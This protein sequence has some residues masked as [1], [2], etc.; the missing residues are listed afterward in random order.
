MASTV[1]QLFAA[2]ART[3]PDATAFVCNDTRLSY[4]ELDAASNRFARYLRRHGAG[5]EAVVAL[6]LEHGLPALVAL[7]AVVKSGAA[8]VVLTSS[9][10]MSRRCDVLADSGAA[11]LVTDRDE[12]ELRAHVTI[13]LPGDFSLINGESAGAI[14]PLATAGN[15]FQ[16]VYTSGSTGRPKGVL[17]PMRAILNRLDAM[18]TRY[19][20]RSDDVALLHR[21]FSIIGSSWDCFGPL[22]SGIRTVI[23][24]DFDPSAPAV[25]RHLRDARISHLAAAPSM[26][27]LIVDQAERHPREWTT[28]RLAIIG[29]QAID[30]EFVRRW[31]RAFPSSVLLNVYGASEAVYP[32]AHD[33]SALADGADRVPAGSAFPN[34]HVHVLDDRLDRQPQGSVGE[35]C[36]GGACL[37]RGYLN[38]PELTAD[39]FVPDPYGAEPGAVLFKT[40]D[41]GFSTAD[42]ILHVV[43]RRDRQVKVHG[44]RI[45]L[46]DV[47][48][49]LAR[50]ERVASAAVVAVPDERGDNQLLAAIVTTDGAPLSVRDVRESLASI[51]PRY[52]VPSSV[53]TLPDM[54]MT[55]SGKVDYQRLP[56]P[57]A[58]PAAADGQADGAPDLIGQ[59]AGIWQDVLGAATVGPCDNFFDL[60]GDSLAAMRIAARIRDALNVDVDVSLILDA[61]TVERLA[62][63]MSVTP[64]ELVE[65]R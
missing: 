53:V 8:Y 29:G 57:V 60:G 38:Q 6:Q 24:R 10:P 41:V 34:V 58:A 62:Q 11:M 3:S 49:A 32:A 48:S 35:V 31:R 27:E 1:H 16:I 42:G 43:G 17:V 36:I 51:V 25:W 21:P 59:L 61:N 50:C 40:G 13:R 33:V 7:L 23:A 20:F 45:D 55:R 56:R 30:V 9:D 37:A 65:A 12:P 52:M 28:L 18:R 26:W 14:D 4:A 47:E 46:G 54:P 5:P 63:S 22:L 39:R 2:R 44:F 15:L 64:P 19:P